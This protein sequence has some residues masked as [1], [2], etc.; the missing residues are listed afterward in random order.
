MRTMLTETAASTIRDC[1][2]P[3]ACR[4]TAESEVELLVASF[5]VGR[6]DIT[7]RV[8]GNQP[9]AQ[10]GQFKSHLSS[11]VSRFTSACGSRGLKRRIEEDRKGA[12]WDS[13]RGQYF[14]SSLQFLAVR[15]HHCEF[16]P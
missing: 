3:A 10:C 13:V 1:S 7:C 11:R 12:L 5:L 9:H 4:E 16:L 8:A 15:G 2:R 6:G 14:R